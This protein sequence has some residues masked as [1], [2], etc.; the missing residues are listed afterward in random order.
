MKMTNANKRKLMLYYT[1][2][3][4]V[5]AGQETA[6][7]TFEDYV[8]PLLQ[9]YGGELMYRVRPPKPAVIETT[10]GYPYEIHVVTFSTEN[11]FRAY[12]DDPQ[13]LQYMPLKEQSVNRVMLIQ[14]ELLS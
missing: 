3:L 2:I 11:D 4:F 12:R 7:H 13:R 10:I 8:L 6:F 5:E 1:Q 14:G 9:R